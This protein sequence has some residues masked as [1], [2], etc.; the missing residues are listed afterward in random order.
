MIFW[1][2][3]ISNISWKT[4]RISNSGNWILSQ[5]KWYSSRISSSVNVLGEDVAIVS[6]TPVSNWNRTILR[7]M[8]YGMGKS[9]R[10]RRVLLPSL[11]FFGTCRNM[12]FFCLSF[13]V[14]VMLTVKR[15]TLSSSNIERRSTSLITEWLF[16]MRIRKSRFFF[17]N[18][19]ANKL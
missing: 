15:I 8:G 4:Q 12:C 6:N 10:P 11:L 2:L 14:C 18:K 7:H 17:S 13:F 16:F 19:C 9:Q 5:R 1:I 3:F